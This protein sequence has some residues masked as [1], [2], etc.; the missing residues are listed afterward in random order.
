MPADPEWL[1]RLEKLAEDLRRE[2]IDLGL[3][4]QPQRP[5]LTLI[6]GGR[7]DA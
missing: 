3:R 4:E 1:V 6:Q 2:N 7:D 5:V